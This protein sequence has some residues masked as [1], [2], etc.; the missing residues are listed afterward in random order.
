MNLVDQASIVMLA[1]LRMYRNVMSRR[2]VMATLFNFLTMAVWYGLAV[3]FAFLAGKYFA[4]V[5]DT[6]SLRTPLQI[7]L[8]VVMAYWQLTPI[9]SVS[10]GLALD[11]KRLLIYPIRPN[12]FFLLELLLCLPTSIEAML[13]SSGVFIGLMLNPAQNAFWVLL[14]ATGF[15]GFN[16]CLSVGMRALVTK[17]SG[18]RLWREALLFLV[19]GIALLP[20]WILLGEDGQTWLAYLQLL[21]SLPFSPWAS[22]AEVATGSAP[23]QTLPVLASLGI[24]AFFGGR[25]LFF[26]VLSAEGS[27]NVSRKKRDG[28]EAELRRFADLRGRT[29]Y[30]LGRL[31]PEPLSALVEKEFLTLAR[32]PRFVTVFIM[33]FT[34]GVVVF[35]PI[36]LQSGG[37]PGFISRNFLTVVSAYAILLMSETVFWNVFGLDRKAVQMFL[38]S[39]VRMQTVFL[40]KNIVAFFMICIQVILIALVC[41]AIGVPVTPG[42]IAEATVAALVLAVNMFALGNQS[43][44]RYP[45]GV[46]PSQSWSSAN[47]GKFRL[48]LMLFFPI[49]SLPTSLA[50]LAR[51][52]FGSDAGFYLGMAIAALI[53]L[54]FYLV[55]LD[56]AIEY[57][58]NHREDLADLLGTTDSAV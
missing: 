22:T 36:I 3:L 30:A 2:G 13:V 8:L 19:I 33:G 15:I 24:A 17:A 7:L 9:F 52:A 25:W 56:S 16:L 55:S 54:S 50:Y 46:N 35:L 12:Q 49:V 6:A 53:A 34:F 31:F 21:A 57:A 4:A 26:R 23:L 40:A 47:K 43:S 37:Q 10:F 14:A 48:V 38:F 51:F 27:V 39:P 18:M 28:N 44:V 20:Q 5:E 11:V 29:A 41:A 42:A 32:S 58:R 1:Q 45:G